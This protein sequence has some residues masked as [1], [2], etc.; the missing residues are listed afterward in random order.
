[1]SSPR[2]GDVYW[3]ESQSVR[4]HEQQGRRPVLVVTD[5]RLATLGL[6]WVVPLTST[7]RGWPLHVRVHV[8]DRVSI[9]LCEQLRSISIERLGRFVGTV[10]YE[11]LSEVRSMLRE[12][13][14]N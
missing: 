3:L 11:E 4:G 5:S 12:I 9:A 2:P 8:A 7:D 10:A 13:I 6:T 14:G 1:M